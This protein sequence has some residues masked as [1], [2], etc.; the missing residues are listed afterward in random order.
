MA[1]AAG[2]RRVRRVL[3]ADLPA[4]LSWLRSLTRTPYHATSSWTAPGGGPGPEVAV[5]VHF[6][7]DGAV[8]GRVMRSL[9]S[10]RDAGLSVFL[11][12]NAGRL[13][14]EAQAALRAVCAGVLVRR[15]VGYDFGALR[16]GLA[17][18]Q[19]PQPG[20]RMVL[21]VNDSV[22]G[23]LTSWRAVLDRLDFAV[24][25]VWGA[26]DS[27]QRSPHLQSWFLAIGRRALDHPAWSAFWTGVRPVQSKEWVIGH[28]EVAFARAMRRHGLRIRA[29]WPYDDLIRRLDATPPRFSTV[30]HVRQTAR[31]R[32][33]LGLGYALNPTADL[34]RQLR[35]AGCPFVKRELV[36]RN[37][38]RV[39]DAEEC[40]RFASDA[41][42]AG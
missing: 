23:P 33:F 34:W 13:R 9:I 14:P 39:A 26:T 20:T 21:L 29:L 25:D 42:Q 38:A 19:L 12:S 7:R 27:R 4:A 37:P 18:W 3:R 8:S 28:Y 15:N 24:A 6:D 32:R 41:E 5:F 35:D 16:E 31:I 40:R 10:L 36:E 17:H 30:Q 22:L 11:V 2:L 1:V